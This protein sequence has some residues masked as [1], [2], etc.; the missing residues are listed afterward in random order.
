MSGPHNPTNSPQFLAQQRNVALLDRA[1]HAFERDAA[2]IRAQADAALTQ[3]EEP[4]ME[5]VRLGSIRPR[6]PQCFRHDLVVVRL[7]F[8]HARKQ[9]ERAQIRLQREADRGHG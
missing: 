5:A 8:D 7:F 2:Q 3:R 9:L 1:F 6:A 4:A